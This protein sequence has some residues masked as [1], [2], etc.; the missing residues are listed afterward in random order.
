MVIGNSNSSRMAVPIDDEVNQR[1]VQRLTPGEVLAILFIAL[2]LLQVVLLACL[3]LLVMVPIVI[4]A[5]IIYR[6]AEHINDE[7][8]QGNVP[9]STPGEVL[10]I[11]VIALF[12]HVI[13]LA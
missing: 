13:L 2:F 7:D 4:L 1:N 9:G 11:L 5:Y 3:A 10:A 12:L 6:M 8:N